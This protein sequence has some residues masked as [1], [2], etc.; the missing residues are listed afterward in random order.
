MKWWEKFFDEYYPEVY[1]HLENLT[2]REVDGIVRVLG[3]KPKKMILD[4]CCGYGRH[5]LELARRGFRVTG[6]DFSS[7]FMERARKEADSLKLKVKFIRGD[8]RKLP[9]KSEFDAVINM[10]TSFG[11]FQNEKEDLQVLRGVNKALKEDGLFLLDTINREF[12]L[13]NFQRKMW[14]PK[15]GFFMLDESVFDLFTSRQ[16]TTRTLIFENRPKRE[17]FFSFRSYT[18]T[19][20]IYNLKRTGFVVEQ[21][22]GDFDFKEYSIDRPRMIILAKKLS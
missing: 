22:F 14:A 16:E 17:Y 19:E 5:C 13:K 6:Y 8:M 18:L 3:L 4:L 15:K 9:F 21:V 7:Y 2:S 10:Y 1:S 11:Y 20:M 12:L